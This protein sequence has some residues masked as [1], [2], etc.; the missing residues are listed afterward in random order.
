M[1]LS[2]VQFSALARLHKRN[3]GKIGPD[4]LGRGDGAGP[5]V[6]ALRRIA[7]RDLM[8]ALAILVVA[9][10]VVA[11]LTVALAAAFVAGAVA[12]AIAG[13]DVALLLAGPAVM[14]LRRSCRTGARL[15]GRAGC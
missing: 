13:S 7:V 11:L 10:P 14:L 9:A 1:V 5:L 12:I 6:G 15:R 4:R 3:F 8:P 2:Q